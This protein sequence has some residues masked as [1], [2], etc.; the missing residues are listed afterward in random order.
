MGIGMGT[1]G[2]KLNNI[3]FADDTVLMAQSRKELQEMVNEFQEKSEKSDQIIN[4]NKTKLLSNDPNKE[5]IHIEEIEIEIVEEAISLGQVIALED[6]LDK[7]ISHRI[8]QGWKNVWSLKYI[9]KSKLPVKFKSKILDSCTLPA[10]MYGS[11]TWAPTEAQLDRFRRTQ[12]AM[13]RSLIGIK[14]RDKIRNKV[15]RE[16]IA[17]RDIRYMIKKQKLRYAGHISRKGNNGWEQKLLNWTPYGHKRGRG[18]PKIRWRDEIR[19]HVG[20]VWQRDAKDRTHWEMIG[21]AYAQ[22]WAEYKI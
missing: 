7:E 11:Q 9:Y 15:V 16:K 22:R 5:K 1:E 3:R 13:E 14:R 8:A 2:D 4:T 6:R 12:L 21:E 17:N 18:R 19:N 10:L 20:L